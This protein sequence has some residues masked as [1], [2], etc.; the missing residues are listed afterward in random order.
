MALSWSYH[1]RADMGMKPPPCSQDVDLQTA[2]PCDT[3]SMLE[4]FKKSMKLVAE[5]SCFKNI[6][7]I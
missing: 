1:Q 3:S 2:M 6:E 4:T 7:T 5:G